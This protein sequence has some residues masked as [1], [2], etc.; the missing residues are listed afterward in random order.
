MKIAVKK[1]KNNAGIIGIE[2]DLNFMFCL[3]RLF[4]NIGIITA[5]MKRAELIRIDIG[6]IGNTGSGVS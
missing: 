2:S 3:P 4:Q 6:N 1:P 5:K